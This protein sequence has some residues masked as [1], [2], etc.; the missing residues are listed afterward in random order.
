MKAK[1]TI[2]MLLLT[3]MLA[4]LAAC[5]DNSS[6]QSEDTKASGADDSVTTAALTGRDA[7]SDDLPDKN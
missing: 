2:S 3:A 4:G 1:R 5:G 6:G 7:V